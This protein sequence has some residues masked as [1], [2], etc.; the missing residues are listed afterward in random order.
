VHAVVF[1]DAEDRDDIR[2]MKTCRRSCFV[3]K[4]PQQFVIHERMVRQHLDRYVAT[5]RHLF[6]LVDDPHPTTSD[7]AQD[8]I[9]TQMLGHPSRG[10]GGADR[11]LYLV[12]TRSQ[13]L[14]KCHGGEQF[15]NLGLIFRIPCGV[16]CERGSFTAAKPLHKLVRE[17]LN[18]FVF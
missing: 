15:T 11:V 9:F 17:P 18:R 5:Q 1:A 6:R 16:F 8:A 10:R 14:D 13:S 12:P 7:F 2:M 3:L 4:P